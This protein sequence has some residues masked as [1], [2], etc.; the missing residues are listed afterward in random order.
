[1]A[2]KNLAQHPALADVVEYRLGTL[3]DLTEGDFD[4]AIS[5]NT[6]EHVLDVPELLAAVRDRLRPGG[7]LFV[8][9]GPL[10]HSPF[11][12]HGWM[13]EAL[14][15]GRWLPLPWGHVLAPH[16]WLLRRM[17]RYY[18][19]P[20]HSTADWPFLPLNRLA[21][22]DFRRLFRESGLRT[23]YGRANVNSL[24]GRAGWL[25]WLADCRCSISTSRSTCFT[26]SKS[27]FS[28]ASQKRSLRFCEASLN[29][30]FKAICLR[31]FA[32]GGH[33]R[34]LPQRIA[35]EF[36]GH[37]PR[38]PRRTIHSGLG[39]EESRSC[40]ASQ[41]VFDGVRHFVPHGPD[42]FG[43]AIWQAAGWSG[44]ARAGSACSSS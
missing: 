20:V 24:G 42:H 29:G 33:L 17:Q 8:G 43:T 39:I 28:D 16:G 25:G 3:H 14:P 30:A 7:R 12:D 9:F 31:H 10:Y 27:P 11:G 21:V 32:E 26:S 1:M 13:R 34:R 6:L 22:G 19:L 18:G 35:P 41:H 37:K 5:E 38:H 40:P 2:R 44:A 36:V 23:V 15:L 4:A